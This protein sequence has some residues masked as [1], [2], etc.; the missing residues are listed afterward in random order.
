MYTFR[1]ERMLHWD[2]LVEMLEREIVARDSRVIGIKLQRTEP[3]CLKFNILC[4]VRDD[5][6]L[7]VPVELRAATVKATEFKMLAEKILWA[8]EHALQVQGKR[9]GERRGHGYRVTG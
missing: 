9:V 2:R 5:D 4:R 7:E 8:A 1:N 3:G 6:M